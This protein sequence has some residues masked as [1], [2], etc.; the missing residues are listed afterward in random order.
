MITRQM[1]VEAMKTVTLADLE[2]RVVEMA[3]LIEKLRP[4]RVDRP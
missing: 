2:A 4:K 3:A 1:L